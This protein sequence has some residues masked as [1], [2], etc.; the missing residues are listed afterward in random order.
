MAATSGARVTEA[1]R[2]SSQLKQLAHLL[3]RHLISWK[4]YRN[5]I[6]IV[7]QL[8]ESTKLYSIGKL[9]IHSLDNVVL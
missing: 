5:S 6:I 1:N 9:R 8:Y 4:T 7:D 3:W 2:G